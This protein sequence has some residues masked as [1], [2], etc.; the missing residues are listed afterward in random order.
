MS[1]L[2][3]YVHWKHQLHEDLLLMFQL[4]QSSDVLIGCQIDIQSIAGLYVLVPTTARCYSMTNVFNLAVIATVT[5][6]V[7]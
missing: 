2:R 4:R 5:S 6:R 3:C 1:M 7:L